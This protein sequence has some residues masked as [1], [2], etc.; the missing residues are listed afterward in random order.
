MD[1]RIR[2]YLLISVDLLF[3]LYLFY[4][5]NITECDGSADALDINVEQTASFTTTI[6]SF[7]EC[8]TL[9]SAQ[10]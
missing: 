7:N 1:S 8:R 6:D 2:L 5:S 10:I 4:F 3:S 9:T